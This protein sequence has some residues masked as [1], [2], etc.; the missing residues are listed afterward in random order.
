MLTLYLIALAAGAV[1]IAFS[2][3]ADGEHDGDGHDGDTE[4]ELEGD[5][6]HLEA[7]GD[8]GVDGAGPARGSAFLAVPILSLRFWTFFFA[9]G[10]LTGALLTW[11]GAL[12]PIAI[13]SCASLVGW[14]SGVFAGQLMRWARRGQVSSTLRRDH[15]LGATG[16][17][18]L[19]IGRG[20]LGRVRV[21]LED[22]VVD[23]DAETDDATQLEVA[24]PAV[25]YEVRDDGVVLVTS[26]RNGSLS[27]ASST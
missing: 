21:Q 12:G 11:L 1:L 7:D 20:S 15:C 22:R 27:T 8:A 9:F 24:E 13:A 26:A 19:P 14:V 5:V 4:G 6:V 17:V 25:I 10:G 3:F 18:L 2:L 23:F 16:T